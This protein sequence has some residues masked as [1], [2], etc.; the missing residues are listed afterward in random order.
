M[1]RKDLCGNKGM[2]DEERTKENEKCDRTNARQNLY[3]QFH[4]QPRH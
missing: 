1:T 3:C 4:V 2:P